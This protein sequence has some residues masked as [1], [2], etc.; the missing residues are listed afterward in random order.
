MK[1]AIMFG[2]IAMVPAAIT[3]ALAAGR[4]EVLIAL[5]CTGD[6]MAHVMVVPSGGG[7]PTQD[8]SHPCCA[9]GCHG[10]HSRKRAVRHV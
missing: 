3:P 1:A 2:V 8:G 10:G 6:G 9:K 7:Q 5:L 4:N